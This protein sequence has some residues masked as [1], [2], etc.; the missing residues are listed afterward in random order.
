MKICI[1]THKV[2]KG[3]GQGRV[4]YEVACEALA[5]GHEL[6]LVASEIDDHLHQNQQVT[7]V[8]I[9]V[10][11][12]PSA[13]LRNLKFSYQSSRW[14]RRHRQEFDVL[15]INGNITDV[16]ATI[17]A[18]HFVHSAWLKNAYNPTHQRHRWFDPKSAYQR[19]YTTLNAHWEKKAFQKA[20]ALVAVSRQVEQELLDIGV[21]DNHVKTIVN[22]VD[23]NEFCPGPADRAQLGLPTQRV[24]A[25]FVGDIKTPRKNLDT[26]LQALTQVNGL[27]LIVVGST[28]KSPYPQ[29]AK[30]LGLADR[31][32]FLGYRRDVAQIMKAVDFFV[33]PSRYEACSLVLLEAMASGLPIITAQSAGGSELVNNRCGIVLQNPDSVRPLAEAMEKLTY[34]TPLCRE[35]GQSARAVAEDHSWKTM[36]QQYLALALSHSKSSL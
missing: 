13:L 6:I 32:H 23:L 20:D 24:L 25:L 29:L 22:G 18:V 4:N 17:N 2:V 7:W 10:E 26:V 9:P 14:L 12:W 8:R 21:K 31:V 19:L 3:D 36:A 30:T 35:M 15:K 11:G 16:G 28:D 1:V 5:Q 33:F 34:D 27:H